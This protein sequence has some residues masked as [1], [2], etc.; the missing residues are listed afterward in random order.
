LVTGRGFAF[1]FIIGTPEFVADGGALLAGG[2]V[3]ILVFLNCCLRALLSSS[4]LGIPGVLSGPGLK[5]F[6]SSSALGIPGV[7][8]ADG[9]MGVVE[10]SGGNEFASIFTLAVF[11]L[12]SSVAF[13]LLTIAFPPPHAAENTTI[14]KIEINDKALNIES[15]SPK[16][17]KLKIA[18]PV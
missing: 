6:L 5:G 1:F 13:A 12:V 11:A 7:V 8:F 2:T 4:G 10:N 14:D 17:L 3:F 9:G 18:V 15:Y 16:K